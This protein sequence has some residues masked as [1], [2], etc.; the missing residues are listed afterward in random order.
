M[1]KL[2]CLTSGFLGS[3]LSRLILRSFEHKSEAPFL[4][5]TRIND[6]TQ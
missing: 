2:L 6:W 4:S 1:W 3:L 5:M